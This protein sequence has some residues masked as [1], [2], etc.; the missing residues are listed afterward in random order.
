MIHTTLKCPIAIAIIIWLHFWLR[1]RMRLRFPSASFNP[2]FELSVHLTCSRRHP[3]LPLESAR[4]RETWPCH[5]ESPGSSDCWAQA[6]GGI[7]GEGN[8]RNR[9]ENQT[10]S[11]VTGLVQCKKC[12][13]PRSGS[14]VGDG[15]L[16]GRSFSLA[17][18]AVYPIFPY[19]FNYWYVHWMGCFFSQEEA[20]ET[21][22]LTVFLR[23][24]SI[25]FFPSSLSI[26]K[27]HETR[28]PNLAAYCNRL[29]DR[30]SIKATWP[31]SWIENPQG[32]ELVK[33]LWS[34][35]APQWQH[36]LKAVFAF[37]LHSDW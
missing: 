31:P 27:Q 3:V 30:P 36:W 9:L 20:V 18:V 37:I 22:T 2:I 4:R 24:C 10:F 29:K 8:A 13:C 25:S 26:S 28:Y 16:A 12:P 15:Y 21:M 14:Q 6:V 7:S 34:S 33:D 19:L 23:F 17:D 11:F 1:C 32:M 5:Q 35:A